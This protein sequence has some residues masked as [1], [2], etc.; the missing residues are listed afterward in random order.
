M[1]GSGR[2]AYGRLLVQTSFVFFSVFSMRLHV[3]EN[4]VF[5]VSLEGRIFPFPNQKPWS[6]PRCWVA[7]GALTFPR[8]RPPLSNAP[9]SGPRSGPRSHAG[10]C[11]HRTPVWSGGG[12]EA[13]KK[14][15]E[16]SEILI[17]VLCE[18]ICK[19]D[20]KFEV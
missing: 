2:L 9:R 7:C 11:S 17:C 19:F 20:L 10:V 4:S 14:R 5:E 13:A 12:G 18:Y 15:V 1:W 8:C 6:W 3:Q 16:N